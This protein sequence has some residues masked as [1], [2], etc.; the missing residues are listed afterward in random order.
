MYL[1][2]PDPSSKRYFP[3]QDISPVGSIILNALSQYLIDATIFL[4]TPNSIT[5]CG[6]ENWLPA[7][8]KSYP[9]FSHKDL[10]GN[11]SCP[12]KIY[13]VADIFTECGRQCPCCLDV[14]D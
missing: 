3:N 1:S 9:F 8:T 13:F 10:Q 2:F 4:P 6:E 11:D 7:T 12:E 5:A 14:S